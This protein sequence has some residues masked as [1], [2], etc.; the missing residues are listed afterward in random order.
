MQG[1]WKVG[2]LVALFGAMFLGIYAVL[3]KSLFAPKVHT[4]FATFRDAGGLK[5]G[6]PVLMAGVTVGHVSEVTLISPTEARVGL[7]LDQNVQVPAGSTAV[8]PASLIG[9]GDKQLLIETPDTVSR[10]FL[11]PGGTIEGAIQSPL[12]A[13]APESEKTVA[14]LNDTLNSLAKLLQDQ[15]LKEGIEKL[16]LSGSTTADSFGKLALRIDS[17]LASN[18]KTLQKSLADSAA[19]LNDLSVVSHQ[20]AVYAKS[21]KLEK[22]FESVLARVEGAVGSGTKLVEDM[23]GLINDPKIRGNMEHIV[24]N[25]ATMTESGTKI[26]ANVETMTAN[27]IELSKKAIEIADKAS[28]LADQASELLKK[29]QGT[30]DGLPGAKGL[31]VGQVT[32]SADL[33]RESRPGRY[34]NDVNIQVPFQKNTLHIGMYDAFESNKLNLQL[35]QSLGKYGELRLGSYA[36][37]PGVG[38][39]LSLTSG[40]SLRSDLYGVNDPRFDVR[41]RYDFGNGILGWMGVDRLFKRNAPTVGIGIR[42]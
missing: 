25:T 17:M 9:I 27:G 38:V 23:R 28:A 16:L 3:G 19:I 1:A 21:G 20:L 6:A 40:L 8:L 36:S 5:S 13:F 30:L 32:A 10:T 42:R 22:G 18:Q 33:F 11:Q 31:G 29:F 2:L 4:Y 39:D 24:A 26:A 41:F 15:G 37:K 12:S 35:G 14:A 7:A 34:R